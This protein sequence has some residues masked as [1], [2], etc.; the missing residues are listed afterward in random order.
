MYIGKTRPNSYSRHRSPHVTFEVI[1]FLILCYRLLKIAILK[2]HARR[3]TKEKT[4]TVPIMTV[5]EGAELTICRENQLQLVTSRPET[6]STVGA[7]FIDNSRNRPMINDQPDK[8]ENPHRVQTYMKFRCKSTQI[9]IRPLLHAMISS[10]DQ[11]SVPHH[12]I[13]KPCFQ[14]LPS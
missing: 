8:K 10:G 5:Q 1:L 4:G 2:T 7:K 3:K 14:A 13:P 12:L 11:H 9:G 6:T